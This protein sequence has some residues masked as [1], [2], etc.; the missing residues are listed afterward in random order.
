MAYDVPSGPGC[1]LTY[2]YSRIPVNFCPFLLDKPGSVLPR[3]FAHADPSTWNSLSPLLLMAFLKL[4]HLRGSLKYLWAFRS[5]LWEFLSC[6]FLWWQSKA[7]GIKAY[8]DSSEQLPHHYVPLPIAAPMSVFRIALVLCTTLTGRDQWEKNKGGLTH[9][10][11]LNLG[12]ANE[13]AVHWAF[14]CKW[15]GRSWNKGLCAVWWV[16]CPTTLFKPLQN[17]HS[18]MWTE[19]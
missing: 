12:R 13:N 5:S 16:Y 11:Y 2:T 10:W 6:L 19:L 1:C 14:W 7:I 8:F 4:V 3:A 18:H 17:L 15:F 9:E